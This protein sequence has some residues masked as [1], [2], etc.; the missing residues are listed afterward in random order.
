MSLVSSARMRSALLAGAL[1]TTLAAL[2]PAA[3]S[4]GD[5]LDRPMEVTLGTCRIVVIGP[6]D[7]EIVVRIKSPG[8]TVRAALT[9]VTASNGVRILECDT[10]RIGFGDTVTAR[11]VATNALIATITVPMFSARIDRSTDNVVVRGPRN[12]PVTLAPAECG[13]GQ[14]DCSPFP[15]FDRSFSALGRTS[16]DTTSTLD[17]TGSDAVRMTWKNADARVVWEIPVPHLDVRAGGRKATGSFRSGESL[18][19][20]LRRDGSTIGE[21]T[22]TATGTAIGFTAALKRRS[23]SPVSIANGDRVVAPAIAADAKITVSDPTIS[24]DGEDVVF[25]CPANA[26]WSLTVTEGTRL[27]QQLTGTADGTG[28]VGLGSVS[29]LGPGRT[30]TARCANAAGDSVKDV[31]IVP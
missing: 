9:D 8:G 4:A 25:E 27:I 5:A 1:L 14:V 13:P 10:T 28:E 18:T 30:V 2:A 29:G 19:V 16:A 6:G 20:Q 3:V 17:L 26:R 11:V 31:A 22:A 24:I 7:T 12:T 15:A 21:G 23:G